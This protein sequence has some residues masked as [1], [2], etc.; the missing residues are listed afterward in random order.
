MPVATYIYA[1]IAATG[2]LIR[3]AAIYDSVKFVEIKF[4]WQK[5]YNNWNSVLENLHYPNSCLQKFY[6]YHILYILY[7]EK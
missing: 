4:L 2:L 3:R 1:Q 5:S 6:H 7:H